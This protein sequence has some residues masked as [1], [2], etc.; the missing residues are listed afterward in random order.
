MFSDFNIFHDKEIAVYKE[1]GF[2]S[3]FVSS[4]SRTGVWLG[5]KA[6]S[7]YPLAKIE[8][9]SE[10]SLDL[11]I[12]EMERSLIN[13]LQFYRN[14]NIDSECTVLEGYVLPTSKLDGV[15]KKLTIGEGRVLLYK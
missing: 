2:S 7:P 9:L 4:R 13:Q 3:N 12:G 11:T 15:S 5:T 1:V 14:H 10:E 8:I 6:Q